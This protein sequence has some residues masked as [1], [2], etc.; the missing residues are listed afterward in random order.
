MDI[1]TG[2]DIALVWLSLFCLIG[3]LVPIAALYFAIRGMN[4]AQTKTVE[5]LQQ[6]HT[7]AK[8][9]HQQT[10]RMSDQAVQPVLRAQSKVAQA[11]AAVKRITNPKR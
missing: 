8:R 10:E 5:L 9:I 1:S 3:L 11:K 6:G 7:Q 2:R 4:I